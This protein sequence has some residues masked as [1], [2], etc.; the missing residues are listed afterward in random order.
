ME[1][2]VGPKTAGKY[3]CTLGCE[4]YDDVKN[5]WIRHESSHFPPEVW[6]CRTCTLIEEPTCFLRK[7]LLLRHQLS[8]H[9][10]NDNEE[11][12]AV[13]NRI[14]IHNSHFPRA[15][16]FQNCNAQFDTWDNRLGHLVVHF[17]NQDSLQGRTNGDENDEDRKTSGT[18]SSTRAPSVISMEDTWLQSTPT[19]SSSLSDMFQHT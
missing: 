5:N 19:R 17:S 4:W 2:R 13:D 7:D 18:A 12:K 14:K 1:K 9:N 6:V 8:A 16:P 11:E 15:C 10:G 3:R